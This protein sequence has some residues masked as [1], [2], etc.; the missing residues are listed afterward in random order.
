M[1]M[2]A[3]S[4]ASTIITVTKIVN[5]SVSNDKK[6]INEDNEKKNED[7]IL[8]PNVMDKY[9]KK[10][11]IQKQ[12][13][14]NLA[15]SKSSLPNILLL[16]STSPP[17]PQIP[18]SLLNF[19]SKTLENSLCK[20][21][22]SSNVLKPE[23]TLTSLSKNV[24]LK[25]S[26]KSQENEF[27]NFSD[28]NLR[29]RQHSKLTVGSIHTPKSLNQGSLENFQISNNILKSINSKQSSKNVLP[30]FDKYFFSPS[31]E[32]PLK[33]H[34]FKQRKRLLNRRSVGQSS[35]SSKSSLI[36]ACTSVKSSYINTPKQIN[37]INK[38]YTQLEPETKK[39]I[40][41][42]N[43]NIVNNNQST[44]TNKNG[45]GPNETLI[46]ND[47]A[48]SH[49]SNSESELKGGS[50]MFFNNMFK[51]DSETKKNYSL[52]IEGKSVRGLNNIKND[53]K[54]QKNTPCNATIVDNSIKISEKAIENLQNNAI[55]NF[56]KISEIAENN[57]LIEKT[58]KILITETSENS[59]NVLESKD[60]EDDF[61]LFEDEESNKEV[62]KSK[63]RGRPRTRNVGINAGKNDV[64]V[65][66]KKSIL[67][68]EEITYN[69][70]ILEKE[71][72][73]YR[74][75]TRLSRKKIK[76]K[77]SCED[78]RF[79][80][81]HYHSEDDN[82]AINTDDDF[83][84]SLKCISN[85]ESVS[86]DSDESMNEITKAISIPSPLQE[87]MKEIKTHKKICKRG[88]QEAVND[89]IKCKLLPLFMSSCYENHCLHEIFVL[90]N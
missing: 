36:K 62:K 59:Q 47:L 89:Y 5:S 52:N 34:Q 27:C 56:K 83:E 40:D 63:K 1:K 69:S 68:D 28:K 30:P 4:G 29:I 24:S 43:L 87:P 3:L 70:K 8:L 75:E 10:T 48:N 11:S 20:K 88:N 14:G 58:D 71:E 72:R 17:K 86:S 73:C 6:R 31:K 39:V 77:C 9:A 60:V 25:Q 35:L 13:N 85:N 45:D 81:H 46:S 49:G 2:N 19:S 12:P 18:V 67:N 51:K 90:E 84:L 64:V 61:K 74:I 32:S 16:G 55:S 53:K 82:D 21:T 33:V 7:N 26:S 80:H 22:D 37:G 79:P 23:T 78:S 44:E 65:K 41:K 57:K 42:N 66:T 38:N 54:E 76:K 50:I 15:T